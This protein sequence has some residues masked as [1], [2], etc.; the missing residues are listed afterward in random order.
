MGLRVNTN[1]SSLNAQRNLMNVTDRLAGNFSRLASGLR[2]ASAADD[3]AGLGISERMRSQMHSLT[4]ATRNGQ[5]GVSLVQVAEGVLHEDNNNLIRMRELAMQAA[6]GTLNTGDRNVIDVEFQ[7]LIQEIDRISGS[8]TFNGVNLLDDATAT[9]D[10]QIGIESGDTITLNLVDATSGGLGL[11]SAG[12]DVLTASNATAVLGLIDAA[13]DSISTTRGT[14]GAAQNRMTS[15]VRTL[16]S[17]H[18]N[19]SAAESRIR[20]IDVAQETADLTRNSIL[21]QA[22]ISILA[23]ANQQPGRPPD[24]GG[25]LT[26]KLRGDQP[27]HQTLPLATGRERS[28]APDSFGVGRA[29]L[30][31]RD[32]GFP[33]VPPR[34]RRALI[35]REPG[36]S[37]LRDTSLIRGRF[38]L[39]PIQRK[40][41]QWDFESTPTSFR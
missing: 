30:R 6:N 10:I 25:S 16:R 22:A 1:I 21:Q 12:F 17:A 27:G 7:Q 41:K 5:D 37:P 34:D 3:A 35:H 19:L 14:L 29:P 2:I 9:I 39:T 11:T 28:D 8:A 38:V 15:A 18:T 4:Q 32:D 31:T 23:Q 26:T 24:F 33:T 13:I 40:R 36:F 20:D